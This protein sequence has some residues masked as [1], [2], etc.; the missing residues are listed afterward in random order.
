VRI[1]AA[2]AMARVAGSED[3]HAL[4]K[5]LQDKEREVRQAA[6]EALAT[7][8]SAED[9][10]SLAELVVAYPVGDVGEKVGELLTTLDRKLY[11]PFERPKDK[12]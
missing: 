7:I 10:S 1:A 6:A 8:G 3:I 12:E 2:K 5:M 4:R 11:C 9:L